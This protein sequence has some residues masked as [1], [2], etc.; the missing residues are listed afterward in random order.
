MKKLI[1]IFA[2]IAGAYYSLYGQTPTEVFNTFSKEKN[3][4]ALNVNGSFGKLANLG[5]DIVKDIESVMILAFDDCEESLKDKFTKEVNSMLTQGYET[6]IRSNKNDKTVRVLAK[7]NEDSINELMVIVTG[8][9]AALIVVKG[10]FSKSEI[11]SK[12]DLLSFND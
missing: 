11:Q 9:K 12:A 8:S 6:L 5:D 2:L 3:V 7:V 1:F 10:A 4:V